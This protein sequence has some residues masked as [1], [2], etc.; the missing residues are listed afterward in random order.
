VHE[1]ADV[2]FS[3][4]T[5]L[6]LGG[7]ARRMLDA[8]TEDEVVHAIASADDP[9][10]VMSGGSNLVVSD[11]GFDGAVV[12]IASRGLTF[13]REGERVDVTVAAGEPWDDVVAHCVAEGLAG[14][15]CLSGIPGSTGATPIQNVGAYGEEVSATISTVRLYD[16]AERRSLE[17]GGE[18]C[19]FGYRTSA[20]RGQDRY[21][22]LTVTYTLERSPVAQPIG[23]AELARKLD[24]ELGARPPLDD[25]R[26]AVLAL[27]RGKGMVIDPADPDTVSA[28]SF[29]V[30]PILPREGLDAVAERAGSAPPA[31]PEADGRV[32][33]SAA[34]LIERA[35]FNRGYGDGRVGVS[36]KHTLALINR[37]GA[38]T[39][40]L[41]AVARELRN[42]VLQRFGVELQVEPTLVGVS[43]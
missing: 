19:G 24:V 32:K 26:R 20:L 25:V 12:R 28:G 38:T 37:G 16:R 27:R 9:V 15:E 30:N 3:E 8:A 31:W 2:S 14:I 18:A 6:R 4:L 33:T 1:R 29:F 10:L 36:S 5:T 22:V 35:G 21:V 39:A 40:E 41:L 23:Y 42:G 43:L 17:L 7:P 13:S 11:E 34:W